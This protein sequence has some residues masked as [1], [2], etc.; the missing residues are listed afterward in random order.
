[1]IF[2]AGVDN[3]LNGKYLFFLGNFKEKKEEIDN[4]TFHIDFSHFFLSRT[5]EHIKYIF[6]NE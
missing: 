3:F 4:I 1:M 6:M 2:I 5:R